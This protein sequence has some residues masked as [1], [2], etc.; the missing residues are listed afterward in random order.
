MDRQRRSLMLASLG[1]GALGAVANIAEARA[2]TDGHT[3]SLADKVQR[4]ADRD[5]VENTMNRYEQYLGLGYLEEAAAQFAL[6]TAD[7]KA[8]IGFGVYEGPA[9]IRRLY[10]GLHKMMIGDRREP[11]TLKNGAMYMLTNTTGT[12]EV[13]G[14][15]RTAKGLWFC[16]G[17]STRVDTEKK[18]ADATW[19]WAKR[20]TDFIRQDDGWKIWH[21]AVYGV[22]Y[23]PFRKPWTE[24]N[25]TANLNFSWIPAGLRPDRPSHTMVDTMYSLNRPVPAVPRPPEPYWTFSETFSYLP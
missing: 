11:S 19:A 12:I 1:A 24:T 4:L 23:T 13:A 16:P 18:E 10:L 7:V 5:A 6:K 14:D 20:A 15:G 17:F 3:L 25:N 21:Y 2:T 8:D 22:F 9:S